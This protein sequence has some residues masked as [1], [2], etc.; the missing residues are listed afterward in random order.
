MNK[1]NLRILIIKGQQITSPQSI[2]I[3]AEGGTVGRADFNQLILQDP[4]RAIS[5]IQGQISLEQGKFY[6]TEKGSNPTRMDGR[7]LTAGE[8]V[9]LSAVKVIQIATYSI[10]CTV[11]NAP[12]AGVSPDKIPPKVQQPLPQ[13]SPIPTKSS[14][15]DD[16]FFD[17]PPPVAADI[18]L[19]KRLN[20]GTPAPL[21]IPEDWDP[22]SEEP[23]KPPT[24][25]LERNLGLSIEADFDDDE[26][27]GDGQAGKSHRGS[28]E[29]VDRTFGL[30]FDV[31]MDPFQDHILGEG[32]AAPNT[33]QTDD[34]LLSLEMVTLDKPNAKPDQTSEL[35][36]AFEAPRLVS[37]SGQDWKDGFAVGL[38]L[39]QE[40]F[41]NKGAA[42]GEL[43]GRCLRTSIKALQELSLLRSN[44]K[45]ELRTE[46]TT[47]QSANNNPI[48]AYKELDNVI[49]QLFVKTK[50]GFLSAPE[51]IEGVSR[52]LIDHQIAIIEALQSTLLELLNQVDPQRFDSDRTDE[53]LVSSLMGS[54]KKSK[55]WDNYKEHFA[56]TKLAVKQDFQITLGPAFSR[57]Y[58]AAIN[59]LSEQRSKKK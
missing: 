18:S 58:D 37:P 30:N 21:V 47:I 33:A 46:N 51:A 5:R 59:R 53:S 35:K 10:A 50:P 38:G 7:E 34:P 4:D 42:S 29:S 27:F 40:T 48:K 22:F 8:K 36:A 23:A 20:Q 24:P 1:L 32:I 11:T 54:G 45:K 28:T 15:L 55:S 13:S 25:Q 41:S 57:A 31:P 39:P 19:P 16:P 44:T 49:Q 3:G 26:F 6:W 12:K 17:L 52:D 56:Q 14:P 43:L 9:D 2:D